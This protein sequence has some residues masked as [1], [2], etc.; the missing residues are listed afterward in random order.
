MLKAL[1]DAI[2]NEPNP[3]QGLANANLKNLHIIDFGVKYLVERFGFKEYNLF[4]KN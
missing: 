4:E 1:N 2:I 3:S